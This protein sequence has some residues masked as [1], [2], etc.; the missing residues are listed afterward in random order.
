MSDMEHDMAPTSQLDGSREPTAAGT[1][2]FAATPAD[3]ES[4]YAEARGSIDCVPWE[5]GRA[6]PALVSWLNVIAPSLIRCGSRVAVVGCGLGDDARELLKRGYDVTAFD[7]SQTAIQWARQIDP[8]NAHCYQC[9]D[10]FNPDPHWRHRFDLVVE[11]HTLQALTPASQP[12]GL[13]AIAE[14]MTPHGHLLVITEAATEPVPLEAGPPWPLTERQ[15]REAAQQAGL[16]AE[17]G[18]TSFLDDGVDPPVHR[19]RAMFRRA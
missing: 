15:L 17:G 11:V 1:L 6:H 7:C 9:A 4:I 13:H 18:I 10:L 12:I 14:L 5:D 8:D 19:I 16:V 2:P 3:Y